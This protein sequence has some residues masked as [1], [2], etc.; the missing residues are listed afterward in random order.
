M[1]VF[2]FNFFTMKTT[3]TPSQQTFTL[4]GVTHIEPMGAADALANENALLVDVRESEELEIM[5]FDSDVECFH[6]PLTAIA[7]R[8]EELPKDRPLIIACNNGVRSVKVVN[9][10]NYQGYTN[11]TNLDGG[12]L[13]WNREGLSLVLREDIMNEGEGCNSNSGCSGCSCGC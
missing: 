10:L 2:N 5:H 9:L 4:Q 8:F 7:D 6:M 3:E 13:Q 11:A 1:C 12:M